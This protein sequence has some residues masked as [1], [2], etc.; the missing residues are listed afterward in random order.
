MSAGDSTGNSR[1][2]TGRLCNSTGWLAVEVLGDDGVLE[3]CGRL[4]EMEMDLMMAQELENQMKEEC[5]QWFDDW[6]D[7]TNES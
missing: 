4:S 5:M 2:S 7:G 3:W 6:K 1:V